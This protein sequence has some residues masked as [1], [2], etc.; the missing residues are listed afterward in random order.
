MND[1]SNRLLYDSLNALNGDSSCVIL[2]VSS[3]VNQESIESI[4][5]NNTSNSTMSLYIIGVVILFLIIVTWQYLRHN[6]MEKRLFYTN[7]VDK[8][9][10]IVLLRQLSTRIKKKNWDFLGHIVVVDGDSSLIPPPEHYRNGILLLYRVEKTFLCKL[11]Q[12]EE[13][14]NQ[15]DDCNPLGIIDKI[16]QLLSENKIILVIASDKETI[17]YLR[18]SPLDRQHNAQRLN[19]LPIKI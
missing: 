7:L 12:I 2:D 9:S 3:K 11:F 14:G 4:V 18:N 13:K 17:Y 15:E 19:R 1:T 16:H 10:I 5:S 8:E 6:S